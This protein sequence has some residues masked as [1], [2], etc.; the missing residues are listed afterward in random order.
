MAARNCDGGPKYLRSCSGEIPVHARTRVGEG[1]L[2][3]LPGL[4]ADLWRWFAGAGTRQG[5]G[6][7]AAQRLCAAMAWWSVDAGVRR[8]LRDGGETQGDRGAK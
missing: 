8:Q 2:G 3:E 7:M 1:G 5:G 4:E 6:S